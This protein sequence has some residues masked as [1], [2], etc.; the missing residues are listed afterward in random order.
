MTK[1]SEAMEAVVGLY[2]DFA[3]RA[4]LGGGKGMFIL[5]QVHDDSI[6]TYQ[7][8]IDAAEHHLVKV[9]GFE[10][11]VIAK[12]KRKLADYIGDLERERSN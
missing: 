1:E 11:D 3:C 7:K 4:L 5:A 12:N 6:E 8:L 2:F 10:L 9:D